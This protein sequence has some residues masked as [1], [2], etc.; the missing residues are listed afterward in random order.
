MTATKE[1]KIRRFATMMA[2]GRP[3]APPT[4]NG[5]SVRYGRCPPASYASDFFCIRK[6]PELLT[7]HSCTVAGIVSPCLPAPPACGKGRVYPPP[8]LSFYGN[9]YR[10]GGIRSLPPTTWE[11]ALQSS[12]GLPR[13]AAGIAARFSVMR[14]DTANATSVD[15]RTASACGI[16]TPFGP[17]KK[18][19]FAAEQ[20][21]AGQG[22]W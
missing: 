16:E 12:K 3:G 10:R 22:H 1:M 20:P 8:A 9:N 21:T 13:L 5:S 4:H 14:W 2:E 18:V 6:Q 17:S 11:P 19:G 7:G 15:M